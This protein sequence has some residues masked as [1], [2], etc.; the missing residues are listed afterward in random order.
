MRDTWSRRGVLESAGVSASAL[1]F[2]TTEGTGT[3][4]AQSTAVVD[5]RQQSTAGLEITVARVASP[6]DARYTLATDDH[7]ITF[8]EG[9]IAAGTDRRDFTVTLR[10]QLTQERPLEF[11]LYS[12]DGGSALA[13]DIAKIS[14]SSG[15]NV[16]PGL[17]E[18]KVGADPNAGFNYPYYLYVPPAKPANAEGPILV[19]PNNT[20]T[21]TD[22]FDTHRQKALETIRGNHNGGTGRTIAD[23]LKVPLLVPVFPRPQSTPV[24]Y[25]HYVHQ[26]DT[27]TMRLSSGKLERVDRQLL[28]MAADARRRLANTQYTVRQKLLLTGFSASGNFVN[29]FAALHPDE[30]ISVTAG[31]I[32]GTAILPLDAAKGHT[33]N[34]QIGIADLPSLV[35]ESFDLGSFRDVDQFLYMGDLDTNDTL[36]YGDAWSSTQQAV[37][38]D[39]YGPNMQRDRMPYCKSV[40]DDKG[41]SAAFKI[42]KRAGHSP[43]P[44]IE[45]MVE[46][47]RESMAGND[48]SGFGGNVGSSGSSPDL[49]EQISSQ[50][51]M[52]VISAYNNN[53]DWSDV[54]D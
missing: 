12:K 41:V 26:L 30:V 33:L 49:N 32:N 39:V 16:Y 24:D 15:S 38:Y 5:L 52:N 34:Y 37:A 28:E 1:A 46:F 45:D 53:G 50:D 43:S 29:R 54:I 13:K 31:G 11:T 25:T 4:R 18:T 23:R 27:E 7:S 14:V 19:E 36:P 21:S 3:G 10:Q 47:H 17:S 20:G 22:D 51:V 2:L 6:V 8:A 44:A 42:Y 40:Y 48:I 35:G 9:E